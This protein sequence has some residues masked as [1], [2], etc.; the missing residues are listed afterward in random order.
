MNIPYVKILIDINQNQSI[1][2]KATKVRID[3]IINFINTEI[4]ME[5]NLGQKNASRHDRE[6]EFCLIFLV[7][8]VSVILGLYSRWDWLDEI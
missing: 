7:A 1:Y 2:G 3:N 5:V 4:I 6:D 8:L